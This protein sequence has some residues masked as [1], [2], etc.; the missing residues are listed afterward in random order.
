MSKKKPKQVGNI[1]QAEAQEGQAIGEQTPVDREELI[2]RVA[3]FFTEDGVY[4]PADNYY[5][6]KRGSE[7]GDSARIIA[8]Y[9]MDIMPDHSP[10]SPEARDRAIDALDRTKSLLD[11]VDAIVNDGLVIKKDAAFHHNVRSAV[12]EADQALSALRGS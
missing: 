11:A 4:H 10:V 1:A 6:V 7:A 3:R 5:I 12:I 8:G 9:L 2:E